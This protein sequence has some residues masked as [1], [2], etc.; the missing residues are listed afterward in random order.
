M[1][2]IGDRVRVAKL[3]ITF[4]AG[5]NMDHNPRILTYKMIG[6]IS[7]IRESADGPQYQV[8]LSGIIFWYLEN[9]LEVLLKAKVWRTA[10]SLDEPLKYGWFDST[11]EVIC[12]C[13]ISN[14]LILSSDGEEK[15]CDECGRTYR[16]VSYVEVKESG[17][18]SPT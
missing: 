8:I 12:P 15:T 10:G 3:N 5:G 2:T 18:D 4:G 17:E 6:E 7:Q 11:C 16:L 1:L 14:N 13:G 9:E